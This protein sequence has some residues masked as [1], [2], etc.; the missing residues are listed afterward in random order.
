MIS[1]GKIEIS[2]LVKRYGSLTVVDDVSIEVE[3]GEFLTLLGSSGC[4][5]TTTLMA[6]AG[7]VTPDS[8]NIKLNGRSIIGLPPE[9]RG[10][11]VVFQSY[12]L[13]PN[14]NVY[15]N[16]AFPLRLRKM[17]S[18]EVDKKVR[19]ALE[20]V[21]LEAYG[22]RQIAEL[23]GGQQQRVALA[24]S[25]VF[26]PSILLMDEPLS[27]LDRK[28]RE[29]LQSEIK[30]IQRDLGVT[31]VYVTH[32]QDEALTMSDRIAI[33]DHGRVVQIGTPEEVY[34]KPSNPFVAGF[35]GESNFI[36]VTPL[37]RDGG[38]LTVRPLSSQGKTL[39]G[40]AV[41][42]E[43]LPQKL[44][45]MIRPDAFK[46]AGP[47]ERND[48]RI[49]V[50]VMQREYLG[51]SIRLITESDLGEIIAKIPRHASSTGFMPGSSIELSWAPEDFL[52]FSEAN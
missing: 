43:N 37:E 52:F 34:E 13:F 31:V 48:N 15:E 18:S 29:Q 21:G 47:G 2:N 6:I 7:F 5:K 14:Y 35:L 38:Y 32:D 20:L 46:M 22:Q 42:D 50:K 27:A 11:G 24:R 19:N 45:G 3:S 39:K 28:M 41:K 26:S 44:K 33:M 36:P 17:S 1:G 9:D 23:S 40:L 49:L 16:I 4:G 8:G 10:L 25:F 30:K 12:A 51:S